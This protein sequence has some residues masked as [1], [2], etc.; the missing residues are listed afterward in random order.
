MA[1]ALAIK[2]LIL[3][4]DGVDGD[5]VVCVGVEVVDK[6]LG[7]LFIKLRVEIVALGSTD[8]LLKNPSH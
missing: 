4:G 1:S 8:E 2:G 3:D 5:A 7:V 6:V